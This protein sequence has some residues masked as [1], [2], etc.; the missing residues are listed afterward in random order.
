MGLTLDALVP[1]LE[2]LMLYGLY[3]SDTCLKLRVDTSK[4]FKDSDHFQDPRT[5]HVLDKWKVNI[6]VYNFITIGL[7]GGQLTLTI[8]EFLFQAKPSELLHFSFHF[9]VL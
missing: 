7:L 6:N 5:I 8:E 1:N 3:F 2:A 4:S 9:I